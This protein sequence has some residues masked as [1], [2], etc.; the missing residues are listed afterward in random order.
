M[1]EIERLDSLFLNLAQQSHVSIAG[2]Q[3]SS[4]LDSWLGYRTFVNQ[5]FLI[6]T[7]EN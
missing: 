3:S 7:E 5:S 4:S 6:S 1:A 2:I